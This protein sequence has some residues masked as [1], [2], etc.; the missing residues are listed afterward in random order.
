MPDFPHSA[1]T[2]SA[3]NCVSASNYLTALQRYNAFLLMR[4]RSG[5]GFQNR[6]M[7]F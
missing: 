4:N 7:L 2:K 3:K 1:A 6:I 5:F